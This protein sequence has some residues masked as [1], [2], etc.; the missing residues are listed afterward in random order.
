MPRD[1]LQKIHFFLMIVIYYLYIFP[2][3]E[4]IKEW[5]APLYSYHPKPKHLGIYLLIPIGISMIIMLLQKNYIFILMVCVLLGMIF[6]YHKKFDGKI[7]YQINQ[8]GIA[9]GHHFFAWENITSYFEAEYLKSPYSIIYI[10]L[11]EHDMKQGIFIR[12]HRILI[13]KEESFQET[14]NLIKNNIQKKEEKEPFLD[15]CMNFLRI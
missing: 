13:P 11:K 15:I 3:T 14:L 10:V 8:E 5:K 7:L 6:L 9:I 2:M 12:H 4:Y 1:K